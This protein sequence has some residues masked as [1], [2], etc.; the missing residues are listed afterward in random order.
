MT[1]ASATI[2][3]CFKKKALRSGNYIGRLRSTTNLSR[4]AIVSGL[5]SV[6]LNIF[7][8]HLA[9]AGDNQYWDGNNAG[10]GTTPNGTV[11]GGQGTW[12][13]SNKNWTDSGGAAA[14]TGWK[15]GNIAIF[16]G[17]GDVVTVG[18]FSTLKVGGLTFQK[19]GYNISGA[20]GGLELANP[21]TIITTDAG[22][23]ATINTTITG[24][25]NAKLVKAGAG[26]V[27]FSGANNSYS[28]GTE[29]QDGTIRVQGFGTLGD[30]TASTV[31]KGT[32][33]LD[34]GGTTQRQDQLNVSGNGSIISNNPTGGTIRVNDAT[35]SGSGTIA[36][37]VTINTGTNGTVTQDGGTMAGTADT[38]T[39]F[40][41]GGQVSSTGKIVDAKNVSQIGGTMAGNVATRDYGLGGTGIVSGTI[42]AIGNL[43]QSG[44]EISSTGTQ[45]VTAKKYDFSGGVL[46][47]SVTATDSATIRGTAVVAN[48]GNINATNAITQI[49]GTMGGTAT[50]KD[51][52]LGGDGVVSGTI[53]ASG[54]IFQLGG[55]ISSTGTQ[56]V[57]A[58][59]YTFSAGKLTGNVAVTDTATISGT[60]SVEGSGKLSATNE[61]DQ[62][63]G[64][65]GGTA[66]TKIYKQSDGTLSGTAKTD[67]YDL[68]NTGKLTGAVNTIDANIKGNARIEQGA[69]L[70][71]TN[72]VNQIGGTTAGTIQAPFYNL[73]TGGSVSSTGA[74]IGGKLFNQFDGTM[75][76]TASTETYNL[77]KGTMSGNIVNAI[78]VKQSG[79][80]LSGTVSAQN[81]VLSGNG[82]V[83]GNGAPGTGIIN[84]QTATIKDNGVVAANA[85]IKA[86][87]SI[88]QTDGE[89]RGVADTP[90]YNLSD[91][92]EMSGTIINGVNVN[93]SGGKLSA[94][95]TANTL[96]YNLSN[97]DVIGT[98]KASGT[99]NQSGGNIWSQTNTAANYDL[100][101]GKLRGTLH[102]TNTATI[103]DDGTVFKNGILNADTSVLQIGGTMDGQVNTVTY[104]QSKGT[105]SGI[106]TANNYFLA[107][108]NTSVLTG[109]VK[110]AN[111]FR[112]TG[113]LM[114]GSVET[115]SYLLSG[116]TL[117]SSDRVTAKAFGR[118][119]GTLIGDVNAD[120]KATAIGGTIAS[121]STSGIDVSNTGSGINISTSANGTVVNGS[122]TAITARE[123]TGDINI[124][125]TGKVS[126]V[127]GI[128]AATT[129][130]GKVRVV[131]RDTVVSSSGP[132]ISARSIDGS[133]TVAAVGNVT[134]GGIG[135]LAETQNGAI[136]VQT[137][138]IVSGAVGVSG[139]ATGTG[140]VNIVTN[141]A[142]QG[143]SG[144]AI[145]AGSLS[146]NI[147][148]AAHDQVA[149]GSV[150]I[151]GSS[152]TGSINIQ[153]DK[154]VSGATGIN[155]NT[156]GAGNVNV[157][158][159][160]GVL[161]TSGP[162]ISAGSVGGRVTISGN[163]AI[164][165]GSHGVFVKSQNGDISVKT[166]NTISGN[167]AIALETTGN[168][169]MELDLGG[170]VTATDT[171]ISFKGE[172]TNSHALLDQNVTAGQTALRSNSTGV[173]T[174][175][176]YATIT[177]SLNNAAGSGSASSL[178]LLDNVAGQAILNNYGQ[179]QGMLASGAGAQTFVNNMAGGVWDMGNSGVSNLLGSNDVIQNSGLIKATGNTQLN[180][181]ERFENNA[182]GTLSLV[183]GAVGDRLAISGDYVGHAGSNIALDVDFDNSTSDVVT[184]GGVLMG[185][186]NL[187]LNGL[188]AGQAPTAFGKTIL[189]LDAAK[190]GDGTVTVEGLPSGGI[191]Q[192]D[193][194]RIGG[195]GSDPSRFVI[196]S[197]INGTAASSVVSG[198]IAAQNVIGSSF[199]KPSS[200]LISAPVD[201]DKNQFG[202]AP[203]I[204]TNGGM[205]KIDT[206]GTIYQPDGTAVEA[207][208]TIETSYYGYQVGLDAGVF[209]IQD[210]GGNVNFG[211]TGGQIFG[212]S[213]QK[214]FANTTDFNSV[215]YGAYAAY[216]KGPFFL[217]FQVRQELMD[218]TVN[219]DDPVFKIKNGDVGGRRTSISGSTSYTLPYK[220]WSFIP[221]TGFTYS[222]SSTDDLFIPHN[223]LLNQNEARVRFS[224]VESLIGFGGI[225][226][227]RNFFFKDDRIRLSPFITAT[228]YHDFAGDINA[229]LT[230]DPSSANPVVLPV[231]TDR[232]KTYGEVSFG[233]NLLALTGKINGVDR[234]VIG[235]VRGDFQYGENIIGG[236]VTAQFRMQ[237]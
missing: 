208:A 57:K 129:S 96:N 216:T 120:I 131:T 80:T 101:G 227:S 164:K 67:S 210:T 25:D 160:G 157:N 17:T 26:A 172:T 142:V 28:G 23:N 40:L 122:G 62:S 86:T 76:G 183:N 127:S 175:D 194:A 34:L 126:G 114:Q 231:K 83:E 201:P 105:M 153:A 138:G 95:G 225:T 44:G 221:A 54:T 33:V 98:I 103:R 36:D 167:T 119:G 73:F 134:S 133:V 6:G 91:N 161:G 237:F 177:S 50:T 140:S 85:F 188:T 49:G 145:S 35:I 94:G 100:S 65:M 39:Y 61:I 109:D 19:D 14:G 121:L 99:L 199:F 130:A 192:Y 53:N 64:T 111:L 137:S 152:Q 123:T 196:R 38:D 2:S 235:S 182:G 136:A 55:E 232:L 230:M 66:V 97:G 104:G 78:D 13:N 179:M 218:Y 214:N 234:L 135:V 45:T 147:D 186:T 155:A 15:D 102:V 220:D 81:F 70:I 229:T 159:N 207:P 215:F 59:N 37:N 51:Y 29:I 3:I 213:D 89:M 144:A 82:R 68:T 165:G 193:V 113:G 116:G 149:G 224:D 146:D 202:L 169:A 75:A 43:N 178:T 7:L 236:S 117:F 77:V 212:K 187:K 197:G 150:G 222:K 200:G 48:T 128:D 108:D 226:V 9:H 204:R 10:G 87:T 31:V 110:G 191:V 12:D 90:I 141:N 30:T 181:L 20:T 132:A 185:T 27:I 184:V 71:A 233:A 203:W 163:S 69:S 156:T 106:A 151:L 5:L 92:G 171:A 41:R 93:Q 56:V 223:I 18:F 154:L 1:K 195:S 42:N 118:T 139:N 174:F 88:I 22:V 24:G 189:V 205:S 16:T 11:D 79:G 125:T 4:F 190:G 176:N 124:D 180:G 107:G 84:V 72:E 52:G 112:Q 173:V 217:D 63:G 158:T 228:A 166:G 115:Q 143:T 209:N 170:A 32:G 211:L 206:K 47:G 60:A 198:F 58:K 46:S 74:I 8:P 219:V 21:S 168:G 162:A 148:V